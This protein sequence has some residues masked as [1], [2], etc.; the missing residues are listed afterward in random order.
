MSEEVK[1]TTAPPAEILPAKSDDKLIIEK[2][3]KESEQKTDD[4]TDEKAKTGD[5]EE[6]A[7]EETKKDEKEDDKEI[8]EDT[9]DTPAAEKGDN[10]K[11]GDEDVKDSRGRKKFKLPHV[12]LKP[13]KVPGFIKSLSK[14]RKKVR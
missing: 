12:E 9:N 13:P 6:T 2:E 5:E 10:D 4:K 14:E 3:E 8:E 11:D 1:T 7:A